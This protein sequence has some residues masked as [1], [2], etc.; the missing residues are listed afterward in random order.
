M[1]V[2]GQNDEPP[3]SLSLSQVSRLIELEQI[4]MDRRVAE[5]PRLSSNVV[6]FRVR[7][8]EKAS[9]TE[10]LPRRRAHG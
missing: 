5:R 4:K 6:E 2:N 10:R 1:K 7:P 3:A 8:A 9:R